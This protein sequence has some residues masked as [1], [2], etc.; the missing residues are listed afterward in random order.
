MNVIFG[1]CRQKGLFKV[2]R[3]NKPDYQIFHCP[4]LRSLESIE[5]IEATTDVC[6]F[7]AFA[8]QFS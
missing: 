7:I 8:S 2:R 4:R 5:N 6:V 3:S 1:G